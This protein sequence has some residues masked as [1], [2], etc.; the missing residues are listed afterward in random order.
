LL[1]DLIKLIYAFKE[2]LS[3]PVKIMASFTVGVI[4][5]LPQ[6]LERA[7]KNLCHSPAQD[8]LEML[9]HFLLF[10]RNLYVLLMIY[11]MQPVSY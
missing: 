10:N 3:I 9:I 7:Y 4:H 11:E 8:A 6:H 5:E 2:D 1:I